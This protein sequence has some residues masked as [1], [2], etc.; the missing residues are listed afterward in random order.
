M[1]NKIKPEVNPVYKTAPTLD[2]AWAEIKAN[3][4]LTDA[5]QAFSLIMQYHNRCVLD[6]EER[7]KQECKH[8]SN[9]TPR[10]TDTEKPI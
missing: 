1:T 6:V 7:L 10:P 9:S 5:N 4:P 8:E 2:A 3:L